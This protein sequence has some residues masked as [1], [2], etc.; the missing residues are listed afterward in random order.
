[1][2]PR[3]RCQAYWQPPLF[4]KFTH[5]QPFIVLKSRNAKMK[6]TQ[7]LQWAH[8][9]GTPLA[10]GSA[11]TQHVP[12][13][14]ISFGFRIQAAL[15][16][17]PSTLPTRQRCYLPK[18]VNTK[19]TCKPKAGGGRLELAVRLV[20]PCPPKNPPRCQEPG[21]GT[22]QEHHLPVLWGREQRCAKASHGK[23]SIKAIFLTQVLPSII[24]FL[25]DRKGTVDAVIIAK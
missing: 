10:Y 2:L 22:E 5:E 4:S 16:N 14:A 6:Q 13:S 20:A 24:N 1:M 19:T 8:L 21:A 11:V 25:S 12:N 9:P 3:K 18:Q 17:K 23:A 15:P 7:H